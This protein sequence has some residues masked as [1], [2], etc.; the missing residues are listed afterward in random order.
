MT[1]TRS[2]GV[3]LPACFA[4]TELLQCGLPQPARD[5]RA[6]AGF[7]YD[8]AAVFGTATNDKKLCKWYPERS[9]FRALQTCLIH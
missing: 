6:D 5:M 3:A 7:L 1:S 2:T 9:A 8:K 4:N